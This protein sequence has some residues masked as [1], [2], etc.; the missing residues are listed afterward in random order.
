MR[1]IYLEKNHWIGSSSC[2]FLALH[3]GIVTLPAYINFND[4]Q[5]LRNG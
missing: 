2:F 1:N 4:I 3:G 5:E